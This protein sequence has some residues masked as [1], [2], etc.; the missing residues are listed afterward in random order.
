MS[1]KYY[2]IVKTAVL[3]LIIVL[4]TA[5]NSSASDT[6]LNSRFSG[7][8]TSERLVPVYRVDTDKNIISIT[9][10]GAWGSSKTE[11][12]LKVFSK[13]NVKVTFFF[14]GIW[15]E[16][17]QALVDKIISSGHRVEN[18]SYTHRH[19]VELEKKEIIKEIEQTDTLI[20]KLTGQKPKFFRPP[21][22]EYNNILI[23]IARKNDYQVIQWS[24]D[25]HDWMNPGIEYVISRIENNIKSGD[26][27]LFHNNAEN[28]VKIMDII[29]PKLKENY[30]IVPLS[31]LILKKDYKIRSFDG[32]QYN[33][34]GVDNK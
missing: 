23:E 31:E 17:N 13:Y 27:L 14:A 18:H 26:I 2:I 32:L 15:L 10:D 24:I 9:V 25:T 20:K 8:Y 6:D 30:Q 5:G 34:T 3:L 16:E 28:I 21:Y 33:N 7:D 12:L 29:I 1:K 22:G 4:F 19:I 11:A